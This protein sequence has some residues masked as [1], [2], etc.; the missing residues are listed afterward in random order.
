MKKLLDTKFG[1]KDLGSLK[2]FLG[3]EVAR[4]E[5]GISLNRRKYALEV[6]SDSG[7]LGCKP[8]RTPMEQHLRLSKDEGELI[9]D[10]SQY[11]RLIGRLMYLTLTRPDICYVV[12]KLSQFLNKPRQLHMLVAVR[13][14]QYIMGTPK[15][16]LFF[17]AKFDFKLKAFCDVDWAGCHNTRKSLTGYCV[18]LGENLISWRSKKQNIVSRPSTEDKYR[19]MASTYCEITW[20]F[21]LLE[22]FRIEHSKA[23]LLYCENKAALHIATNPVFHE[24][25]KHIEIDCHLIRE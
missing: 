19:S 23:A 7:M 22:D 11:R 4:N 8:M 6:L 15:Q 13:V 9:D 1:I 16:G 10:P 24:R 17:S 3:L 20:F 18:F 2:Y 25:T 12:N 5:K 14:L 21:Y